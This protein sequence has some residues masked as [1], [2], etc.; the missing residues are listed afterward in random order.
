MALTIFSAEV[1]DKESFFE[2]E[3]SSLIK[4]SVFR[5]VAS[6]VQQY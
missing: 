5:D 3:F 1:G 2:L 6:Y 4:T